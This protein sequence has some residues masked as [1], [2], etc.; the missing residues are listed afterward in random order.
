MAAHQPFD[1]HRAGD[2]RCAKQ[3]L[4]VSDSQ[5]GNCLHHMRAIDECQTLFSMEIVM[6][7]VPSLLQASLPV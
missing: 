6:E 5:N 7:S 4:S 3:R 2:F 1:A